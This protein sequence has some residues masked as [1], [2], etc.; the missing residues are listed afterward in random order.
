[1]K[2]YACAR[3]PHIEPF[4]TPGMR[5]V[6][7]S[8]YALERQ[9][10]QAYRE[11]LF[12]WWNIDALIMACFGPRKGKKLSAAENRVQYKIPELVEGMEPAELQVAASIFLTQPLPGFIAHV[13]SKEALID[14]RL[15]EPCSKRL[16]DDKHAKAAGLG[17]GRWRRLPRIL[18]SEPVPCA[19]HQAPT[20]AQQPSELVLPANPLPA[21]APQTL[22]YQVK[23]AQERRRLKR[24]RR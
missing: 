17:K 16:C 11:V 6:P 7:A 9:L 18:A 22:L 2:L 21:L 3:G 24:K 14:Y 8:A 10:L 15:D 19:C 12:T 5:R 23:R 4:Y 20:P 1:M 13:L